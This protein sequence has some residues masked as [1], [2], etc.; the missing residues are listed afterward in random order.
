MRKLLIIDKDTSLGEDIC[1]YLHSTGNLAKRASD[2]AGAL[3]MINEEDFEA[4]KQKIL[5]QL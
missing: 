5:G 4:Q 1:N 3:E 2:Y